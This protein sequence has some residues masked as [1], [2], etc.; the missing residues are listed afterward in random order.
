MIELEEQHLRA[1]FPEYEAYARRVNRLL[2]LRH[3]EGG[4]RR[5]EWALYRRNQEYKAGLGF[6][7][8]LAWMLVRR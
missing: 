8:A 4:S 5:F 2:P 7:V 6:A 1:I 3:F